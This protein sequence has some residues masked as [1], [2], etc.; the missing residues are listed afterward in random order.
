MSQTIINKFNG[1]SLNHTSRF[2]TEQKREDRYSGNTSGNYNFKRKFVFKKKEC[3]FTKNKINHIDYKDVDLL[4]RFI[5]R[6]GRIL[7]RRFTGTN[8][9]FQRKL[10]QA[11]KRARAI[12]LLP[13]TGEVEFTRRKDRYDKSNEKAKHYKPHNEEINSNDTI[14]NKNLE[15]IDSINS[16]KESPEVKKEIVTKSKNEATPTKDTYDADETENSIL[17]NKIE[18][19]MEKSEKNKESQKDTEIKSE[20]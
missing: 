17:E 11:I 16:T 3:Y 13:Y 5:G 10:A 20:N 12:A 18:Q 9:L 15:N 19:K 2:S 1:D 8:A 7:P 4:K 6:N 14:S